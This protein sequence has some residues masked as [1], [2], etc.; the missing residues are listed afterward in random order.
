MSV[1]LYGLFEQ[2]CSPT[3]LRAFPSL[4]VAGQIEK[5]RIFSNYL[6]KCVLEGII[7]GTVI[8]YVSIY[9]VS[10]SVSDEG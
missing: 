6:S 4:Y 2:P 1:I 9:I 10:R 8:Y 3:V 7:Q 5:E